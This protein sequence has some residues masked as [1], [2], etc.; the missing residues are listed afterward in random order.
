MESCKKLFVSKFSSFTTNFREFSVRDKE[1]KGINDGFVLN[2][3]S[4]I[5]KSRVCSLVHSIMGMIKKKAI[6]NIKTPIDQL[7]GNNDLGT[8]QRKNYQNDSELN[9]S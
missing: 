8:K 1:C 9:K 3:G 2:I 7:R 4:T 6:D 5:F